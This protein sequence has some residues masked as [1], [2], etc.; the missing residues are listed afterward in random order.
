[1]VLRRRTLIEV[2][3]PSIGVWS[4]Q[5]LLYPISARAVKIVQLLNINTGNVN[6]ILRRFVLSKSI[7]KGEIANFRRKSI[8]KTWF[9]LHIFCTC[10][11]LMLVFCSTWISL[12]Y[13]LALKQWSWRQWE[14]LI[15]ARNYWLWTYNCVVYQSAH[16]SFHIFVLF[17]GQ[18]VLFYFM[19]GIFL[20]WRFDWI[21]KY[22]KL[23]ISF[24]FYKRI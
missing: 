2:Q 14:Y 20:N 19:I 21:F 23:L 12:Y 4:S 15:V 3:K 17:N 22:A 16:N 8:N 6:K 18:M 1:M 10:T 7:L 5:S 13:A 11:M 9:S 24:Y